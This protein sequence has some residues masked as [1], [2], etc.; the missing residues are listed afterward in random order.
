M[1][2]RLEADSSRVECPA[3]GCAAEQL[4]DDGRVH[5]LGRPTGGDVNAR[6]T[7]SRHK[8][9]SEERHEYAAP[10]QLLQDLFGH[11]RDETTGSSTPSLFAELDDLVHG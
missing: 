9:D 1:W 6:R 2:P 8:V 11:G 4:A 10:V 5:L 7:G 3:L